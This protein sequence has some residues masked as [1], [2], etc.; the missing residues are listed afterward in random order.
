[1]IAAVLTLPELPTAWD[2]GMFE[3]PMQDQPWQK[4]N[5]IFGPPDEFTMG[6]EFYRESGMLQL[7]LCYPLGEGANDALSRAELIRKTFPR[8]ASF[9][10]EGITV[11]VAKTA[12]IMDGYPTDENYVIVVRIPFYADIHNQ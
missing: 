10:N 1:M 7:T 12:Y 5:F 11:H 3:P 9:S 6:Q 8:G 2:N 4:A